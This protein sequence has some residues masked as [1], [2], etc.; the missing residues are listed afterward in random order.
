MAQIIEDE[1]SILNDINAVLKAE[2]TGEQMSELLFD[3]CVRVY[4]D[5]DIFSLDQ[6]DAVSVTGAFEGSDYVYTCTAYFDDR[7]VEYTLGRGE[8]LDF[9]EKMHLTPAERKE[10]E[11]RAGNWCISSVSVLPEEE[12]S[13]SERVRQISFEKYDQVIFVGS[14]SGFRY[15]V[16]VGFLNGQATDMITL[17]DDLA[18][19]ILDAASSVREGEHGEK[20]LDY[21]Q[22]VELVEERDFTDSEAEG[23]TDR[24]ETGSE[25]T[26][27][28]SIRPYDPRP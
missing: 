1:T 3:D 2:K 24:D 17:Q 4:I 6:T 14:L 28:V 27:K 12:N 18:Y 15:P 25:E 16:A 13:L 22:V 23:M 5:T 9:R 8:S 10:L 19:P 26:L 21:Q 7:K 11:R 20:I